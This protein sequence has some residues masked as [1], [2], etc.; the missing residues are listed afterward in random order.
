MTQTKRSKHTASNTE[1]STSSTEHKACNIA[2]DSDSS[3]HR[4]QSTEFTA[5][6]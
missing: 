1:C 6:S 5:R 2:Q 4:A 3:E